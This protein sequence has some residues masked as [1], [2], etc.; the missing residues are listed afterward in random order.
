MNGKRT[1]HALGPM[2]RKTA[3]GKL[4]VLSELALDSPDS[5]W[6][7]GRSETP[8]SVGRIDSHRRLDDSGCGTQFFPDV[9]T[10]GE[11]GARYVT[12]ANPGPCS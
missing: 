10:H 1:V 2:D 3:K 6:P 11:L 5:V 4:A 7:I 12:P 9:R 8:D